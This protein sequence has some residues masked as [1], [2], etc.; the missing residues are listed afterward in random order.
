MRRTR[1]A[2]YPGRAHPP[3]AGS[4]S[5]WP[6]WKDESQKDGTTIS[7]RRELSRLRAPSA[8]NSGNCHEARSG[9]QFIPQRVAKDGG[10]LQRLSELAEVA[11]QEGL[12]VLLD[13]D[14]ERLSPLVAPQPQR[15]L[16][17]TNDRLHRR[18]G[19]LD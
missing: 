13:R 7:H 18:G 6:G 2:R 3:R 15:R 14:E 4:R 8:W 10:R 12:P 19:L 16:P 11:L 17:G 5:V 9:Q 1:P